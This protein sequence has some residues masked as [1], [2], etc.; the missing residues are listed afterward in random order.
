MG[1]LGCLFG[2]YKFFQ[3][4]IP[5]LWK[6]VKFTFKTIVISFFSWVIT[7][8]RIVRTIAQNWSLRA[9]VAGVPSEYDRLLYYGAMAI[10]I[11]MVVIGWVLSAYITV[12][13]I[14]SIF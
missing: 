7:I 13:I 9:Q 1:Q 14:S 10:A 6:I 11:L 5:W 2:I 12:W 8:P 3:I 4:V